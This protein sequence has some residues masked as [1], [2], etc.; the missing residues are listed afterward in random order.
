MEKSRKAIELEEKMKN[1]QWALKKL[2]PEDY[3]EKV[4]WYVQ[5][6][7]RV[8]LISKT[9]ALNATIILTN[10]PSVATNAGAQMWFLAAALEILS[11][12]KVCNDEG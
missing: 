7:H 9:D 6:I 11:P 5:R 1:A 12:E 4:N 8:M 2:H 10:L 3:Q